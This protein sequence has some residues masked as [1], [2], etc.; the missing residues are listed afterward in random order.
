[1]LDADLMLANGTESFR[2]R[3]PDRFFDVGV[4]EANLVGVA[5][6]LSRT[7][8]IPF[9]TTFGCFATR[10][11]HDQFFISANYAGLNVKLVGTDPGITAMYNGGTHMPFED[12]ALTRV[13]PKLLVFE[14]ADPVSLK[15][16]MKQ[17]AYHPGCT[18]MRVPRK[19]TLVIYDESQEFRL[20]RG[21]VIKDGK[22]VAIFASGFP[23]VPEAQKAA[24]LLA[25]EGIDAAVIDI[26]TIKPIDSDLVIEYAEKTNR[27]ITCENHQIINGL[28]SAVAEVL[29]ENR[30]TLMK[31]IGINDEFGE[32][33]DLEYLQERFGLTAG[34]IVDQA[35]KLLAR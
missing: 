15:E 7:G 11:A 4:A 35:K 18:Y 6:G 29:S 20:G 23:C 10:R 1:M 21:V 12:T 31:R 2:N 27:V 28:G 33:G 8:K 19:S 14:P 22:D 13:I 25:K 9:A 34:N 3:F 16:L 30:P 17:S 5:A 24:A 32:V 26:H